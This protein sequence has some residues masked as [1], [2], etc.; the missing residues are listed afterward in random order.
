MCLYEMGF[1]AIAA[2]S[3]TTFIP[4]D[5]LQLLKNKWNRVIIL[6]DR[7]KA[8]MKSTRKYSKQYDLEPLFVNKRFKAKDI[9]DAVKDNGFVEIKNWLIKTLNV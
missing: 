1:N 6:Y 7:D 9:S 2:S 5:I 4:D 8:G 3:E